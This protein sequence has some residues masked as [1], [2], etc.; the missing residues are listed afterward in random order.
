MGINETLVV[1]QKE[2]CNERCMW[3]PKPRS[4]DIDQTRREMFGFIWKSLTSD[5]RLWKLGNSEEF[6]TVLKS[7]LKL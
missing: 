7:F 1:L 4:F 2:Y 6:E 5:H 3:K